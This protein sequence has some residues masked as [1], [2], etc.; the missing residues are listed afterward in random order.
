MPNTIAHFAINGLSTR[1]V[2]THADFKWIYL[3]C[4]IPDLPWIVQRIIKKLPL[5]IDLYDLRAYCI[6][7]S[8]LLFCILLCMSFSMLAK[9]RSKV[10]I[11]LLIGSLLH[12]LLDATQIKWANGAQLLA[13][14]N[15][16]LLRF[17]L[18]WPESFATYVLTIL[19]LIYFIFNFK[20]SIQANCEEFNISIK[21]IILS[22]VLLSAWLMSP[23]VFTQSV[24]AADNHFIATLKDLENRTGKKI[25]IDRNIYLQTY[26]EHKI[27]TSYGEI[28]N[29]Q[30][31][32]A[33]VESSS[34]ISLQGIF[35]D[36]HTIQVERYHVHTR[37]RDFA[38]MFGLAC[39]LFIWLFFVGRCMTLKLRPNKLDI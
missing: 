11:I 15:W 18:F 33:E 23:V 7:Q 10:F 30:G 12:L 27:K 26:N 17:D 5:S 29:L 8:S 16:E 21:T 37:F 36:N 32:D 19:G 20:K 2:F 34:L 24:Y 6:T 28:I 31:F 4:V 38:S 22:A 39:V 35:T 14:V 13:P 9:Q 25:E 1:T 3:A